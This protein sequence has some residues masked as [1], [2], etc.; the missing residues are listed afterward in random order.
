MRLRA[1]LPTEAAYDVVGFGLN[2]VDHLCRVPHFPTFDSK[3]EMDGYD[4][5]PGGQVATTLVALARWGLRTT[6]L[7][8]FGDDAPGK[9]VR[10]ALIDAGVGVNDAFVRVGTRNQLA[11]ILIDAASGERTV[12]WHRDGGLAVRADELDRTRVCAGRALHLDGYDRAA[13]IRAARWARAAGIVTVIDLDRAGEQVHELLASVDIAVV[14]REAA[15]QLTGSQDPE[16]VLPMLESCGCLLAGVTL[17][18]DGVVARVEGRTVRMPGFRVQT[19]DTTGAG[20]V[21]HA[22]LIHGVLADWEPEAILQF[23][24]AAAA[25]QC[26]GLGAQTAVPSLERIRSLLAAGGP[27][28]G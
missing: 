3:L 28:S 27:P 14:S 10:R 20:D 16:A 12:L 22:G 8:A 1:P 5:H 23:A 7:G 4:C 6:Y 24:N 11:V 26:T 18:R 17:G 21:F 9:Q 13:A 15:A 25:L 2:A 19:V